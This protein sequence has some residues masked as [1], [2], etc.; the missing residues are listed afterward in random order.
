MGVSLLG[1]RI[2]AQ[3]GEF[4]DSGG[5]RHTKASACLLQRLRPN[6][7]TGIAGTLGEDLLSSPH[8]LTH[9]SS[10]SCAG[11][12]GTALLAYLASVVQQ[13]PDERDEDFEAQLPDTEKLHGSE[14]FLDV[15][16][17]TTLKLS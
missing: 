7:S 1:S 12:D 16:S 8:T 15:S 6:V 5:R 11:S 2:I 9:D 14:V 4:R 3:N 17:S 10:S 13:R